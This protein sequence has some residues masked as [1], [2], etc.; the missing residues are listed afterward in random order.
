MHLPFTSTVPTTINFSLL[1][2]RMLQ[3]SLN[4]IR[5][6]YFMEKKKKMSYGAGREWVTQCAQL[7]SAAKH[8]LAHAQVKPVMTLLEWSS[9]A[10][11]WRSL[12]TPQTMW[13][14]WTT[15]WVC[16]APGLWG[17]T[18]GQSF[19]QPSY[20]TGFPVPHRA[21]SPH[22][23]PTSSSDFP[24][25]HPDDRLEGI[26]EKGNH[27]YLPNPHCC[28]H[29]NCCSCL[30]QPD[31]AGNYIELSITDC[32]LDPVLNRVKNIIA[33]FDEDIYIPEWQCHNLSWYSWRW[34]LY[35][36]YGLSMLN[37]LVESLKLWFFME[38]LPSSRVPLSVSSYSLNFVWI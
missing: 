35:N 6:N 2:N 34:Q 12:G 17:W 30:P 16:P 27:R 37:M 9:L 22:C 8:P 33:A 10:I 1:S 31:F 20:H 21:A 29:K 24:S 14:T 28:F 3:S 32:C 11:L 13:G 19:C 7:D 25:S 23:C 38:L 26:M 36:L 18:S 4:N 5:N 15:N